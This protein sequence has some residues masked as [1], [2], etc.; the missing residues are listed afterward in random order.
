VIIGIVAAA[1]LI[2]TAVWASA[3]RSTAS[4]TS[5]VGV[6]WH[7]QQASQGNEGSVDGAEAI[8]VRTKKSISYRFNTSSL[9]PGN[10]YTVWVIVVNNPADCE[11][12]PC[13]APDVLTN[14]DVDAQVL[15]GT[16]RVIGDSG[17]AN[18]AGSLREG[19]VEGWLPDRTFDDTK[20]AEIHLVLNDHGPEIAELMPSM[21]KTYRAGC[22]DESPFPPIFPATALADGEAG[23]NTCLLSQVAIFTAP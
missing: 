23:P 21:I 19:V 8:L 18:F 6:N 5:T 15:W 16:G 10:A 17:K 20:G 1:M 22:S 9:N 14:P 7:P 13:S 2:G 12:Q 11:A 4:E 3:D